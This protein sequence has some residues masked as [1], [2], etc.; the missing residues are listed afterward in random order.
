MPWNELVGNAI[1]VLS[2]VF[3]VLGAIGV[4]KFQNFYPR[5]IVA[6]KVDT[7][8]FMTFVLGMSVRHGFTFFTAKMWLIVVIVLILN[9]LVTHVVTRAA[10]YSGHPMDKTD[11]EIIDSHEKD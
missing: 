9:P 5:I 8:G 7:V 3:M 10:Y 1:I 2:V 4:F 6:S 11:K